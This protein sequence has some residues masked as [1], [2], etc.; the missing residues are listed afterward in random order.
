MFLSAN[1]VTVL[2]FSSDLSFFNYLAFS[3][4]TLG[5]HI[6]FFGEI[7][8]FCCCGLLGNFGYFFLAYYLAI[9]LLNAI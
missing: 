2:S 7:L 8:Y 3:V 5:L 1:L 9:F 4:P 6:N